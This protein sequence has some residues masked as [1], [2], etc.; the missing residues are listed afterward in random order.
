MDLGRADATT[1]VI[2]LFL[3]TEGLIEAGVLRGPQ[4]RM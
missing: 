3:D 2:L 1:L 4:A